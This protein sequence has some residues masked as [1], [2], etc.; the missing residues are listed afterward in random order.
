MGSDILVGNGTGCELF[1]TCSSGMLEFECS[2]WLSL[3]E[4]RL[5]EWPDEIEGLL[6]MLESFCCPKEEALSLL[7][8]RFI[9][10]ICLEGEET[11][12]PLDDC[13]LLEE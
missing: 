12:G 1:R 4:L 6:F 5:F 7:L 11:C 2:I 13:R 10:Y 3:N 8:D 9:P